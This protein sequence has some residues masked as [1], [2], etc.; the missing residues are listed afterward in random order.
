MIRSLWKKFHAKTSSRTMHQVVKVAR[1]DHLVSRKKIS[2]NALKVLYQLNDAGYQAFLVGGSVRD[3]MLGLSPKDFDVAT[4]ATPEQIK[5]LFRN[6][7]LVGRRFRL[8]HILFGR[9]TIE[10]ATFRGDHQTQNSSVG[11]T[12]HQGL[13]VRDN[14]YGNLEQD[15]FRRDF[16]INALYYS[17]SDFSLLDHV[18]GL[19]DLANK[20]LRLIGDPEQRYREDPVRI[21]RA[22]RLSCKLGLAIETQTAKPIIEL[23]NMLTHVSPA[24][25]WDESQKLFCCGHT[26][27]V[28]QALQ[29][30]QVLQHLLPQTYAMLQ[31]D[32]SKNFAAFIHR[33]LHSTDHRIAKDLPISPAFLFA[34]LLW[35]PM[36]TNAE[37][38]MANGLPG[39]EAKQAAASQV[40]QQ[41]CQLIAIPRRFSSIVREIWNLQPRLEARR[42]RSIDGLLQLKRFRAAYDF[43]CLRAEEDPQLKQAAQWWT[44][45]QQA[46]A[47]VR[48]DMLNKIPK[49][50]KRKYHGKKR[51]TKTRRRS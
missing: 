12:N 26:V 23:A 7:R 32:N 13:L 19:A 44:D 25:L 46:S 2:N 21:L 34:V 42:R 36:L 6:C 16:T 17:V 18:N 33:S 48:E 41:Q 35:Q 40:F 50:A 29:D 43:L 27:A 28:W 47:K 49:P 38:L 9:E 8:A 10:V 11:S 14:V 31:Q 3:I 1:E 4:D 39:Y 51:A 20:Q 24:R 45:Y 37:Q 30:Y 15:A 5:K 22:I